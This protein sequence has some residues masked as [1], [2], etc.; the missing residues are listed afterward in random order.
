MSRRIILFHSEV[1]VKEAG[2]SAGP[3]CASK[4]ED[5]EDPTFAKAETF[6]DE[7]EAD[8]EEEEVEEDESPPIT[9]SSTTG[10]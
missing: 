6:D 7:E 2:V 4:A 1:C 8:E 9:T 10:R 5:N 3:A